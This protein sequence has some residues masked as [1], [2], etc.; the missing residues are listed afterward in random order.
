MRQAKLKQ[1][2][3]PQLTIT[4]QYPAPV[5]LDYLGFRAMYRKWNQNKQDR[6]HAECSTRQLARDM[7]LEEGAVIRRNYAALF[8]PFSRTQPGTESL[9][10]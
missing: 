6:R 9:G 3:R 2:Q 5:L 1:V 4:L 7:F 8:Q 10:N